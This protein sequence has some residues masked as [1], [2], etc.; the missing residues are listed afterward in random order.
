MVDGLRRELWEELGLDTEDLK[1]CSIVM[2]PKIDD[3]IT[4]ENRIKQNITIRFQVICDYEEIKTLMENG[5]INNKSNERGGELD[6]V[7][8]IKLFDLSKPVNKEDWAFNHGEIFNSYH[9][10]YYGE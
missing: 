5:T 4:G 9:K 8:E 1:Y 3:S 2:D 10:H 6:E 7:D